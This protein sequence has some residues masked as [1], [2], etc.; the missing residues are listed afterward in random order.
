MAGAWGGVPVQAL[1]RAE[2]AYGDIILPAV[3]RAVDGL[4]NDR[5]YLQACVT[6]MGMID[7]AQVTDQLA[8]L[9]ATC[10]EL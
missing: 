9:R 7:A 3:E 2:T 5:A 6:G 10:R 8:G 4:L 1:R